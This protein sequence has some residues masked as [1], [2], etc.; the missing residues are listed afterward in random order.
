MCLIPV[1]PCSDS[2]LHNCGY[3]EITEIRSNVSANTKHIFFFFI[4]KNYMNYKCK[5]FTACM[6]NHKYFST[7]MLHVTNTIHK[8]RGQ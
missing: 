8:P 2:I 1:L 4:Y 3:S 6:G 5:Q 7:D